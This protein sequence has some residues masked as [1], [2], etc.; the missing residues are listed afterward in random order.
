MKHWKLSCRAT[1]LIL[2]YE[3]LEYKKSIKT[4]ITYYPIT[5]TVTFGEIF[6]TEIDK[7][8]TG[9]HDYIVASSFVMIHKREGT[10]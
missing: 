2:G 8:L 4:K 9:K 6:M 5:H 10:I 1:K 7:I 3:D